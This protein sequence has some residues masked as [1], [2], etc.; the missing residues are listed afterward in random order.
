MPASSRTEP[1]EAAEW[2][3]AADLA[4]GLGVQ[5]P[6]RSLGDVE[7]SAH[8]LLELIDIFF[9]R[10]HPQLPFLTGKEQLIRDCVAC[11]LLSWAVVAVAARASPSLEPIRPRLVWPI[12]RLASESI[13][14]PRSL[15][16][17]QALLLLCLWPMPY[18]SLID[19]PSWMFSGIATQKALQLGLSR[20][21][22]ALMQQTKGDEKAARSLRCTWIACFI[23]GQMLSDR[24]GIPS[25][26]SLEPSVLAAP[27]PPVLRAVA[28]AAR[29]DSIISSL[30]A[31]Q[32]PGNGL[33]SFLP[34]LKASESQLE[35]LD[36][37]FGEHE[38]PLLQRL[39][40]SIKLRL[41]SCALLPNAQDQD[42]GAGAES[43]LHIMS[44]ATKAYTIAMAVINKA[45][46]GHDGD[47]Y[48]IAATGGGEHSPPRCALWTFIDLQSFIMA[49]FTVLHLVRTYPNLSGQHEVSRISQQTCSMLHACSVVE[50]DHFYRVCEVISYLAS[51]GPNTESSDEDTGAE[52][53]VPT[54]RPS[55]GVGVAHKMIKEAKKR[56]RSGRR[57]PEQFPMMDSDGTAVEAESAAGTTPSTDDWLQFPLSNLVPPAFDMMT[58]PSWDSGVMFGDNLDAQLPMVDSSTEHPRAHQGLQ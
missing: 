7:I 33:Q 14:Q 13:L 8:D 34:V 56:Y 52:D 37:E 49:V 57:F 43:S 27:M 9:S 19:D 54:I 31:Q 28:E 11:P 44:Y 46:E 41:Y 3:S 5:V 32:K 10:F 12:R 58:W 23:V 45:L 38:S 36:T 50:G 4:I 55:I 15:P 2:K 39:L 48:K 21:F 1:N 6:T 24:F 16:V 18:A 26:V 35:S 20:P 42:A 30:L 22:A 53:A 29:K 17:I 51:K 47:T 40:S 25:L